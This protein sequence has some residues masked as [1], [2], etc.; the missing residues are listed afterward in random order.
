MSTQTQREFTGWHML[1]VMLAFFGVIITVNVTMAWLA[2]SSW[3]GLVVKNSY[4]A[5]QEFNGKMAATRAQAA[6]GRTGTL[7]IADGRASYALTDANG[8]SVG[9]RSV[10]L[11]FQ[12]PVD[13]REDHVVMLV[14]DGASYAADT[15]VQD[16]VWNVEISADAGLADPYRETLRVHVN[17]GRMQ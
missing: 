3:T 9:L 15:V 1:A 13:D 14:P 4:V 5:S 12:H 2:N 10:S 7:S 6:L 16:G 11:T 17:G 8:A